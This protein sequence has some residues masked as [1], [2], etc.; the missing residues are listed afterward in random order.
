MS[1]HPVFWSTLAVILLTCALA[2]PVLWALGAV[3]RAAVP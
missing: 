1:K 2:V 3:V